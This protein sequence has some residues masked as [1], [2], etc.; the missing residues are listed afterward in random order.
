MSDIDLAFLYAW[1][2][3][4]HEAVGRLLPINFIDESSVGYEVPD[5]EPPIQTAE[6]PVRRVIVSHPK[7]GMP[8]SG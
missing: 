2:Y 3:T 8:C 1:A 5:G 4:S 6:G 7:L